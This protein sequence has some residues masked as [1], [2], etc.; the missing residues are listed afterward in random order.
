MPLGIRPFVVG[1]GRGRS[2]AQGGT[3][4]SRNSATAAAM[5]VIGGTLL[6]GD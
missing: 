2:A 6:T 1:A 5:V 4:R 3:F